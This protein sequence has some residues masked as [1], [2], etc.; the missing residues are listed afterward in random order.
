MQSRLRAAGFYSGSIDGRFRHST[1]SAIN[2]Y[3]NRP[4]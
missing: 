2:A 4:R 3:F 1:V